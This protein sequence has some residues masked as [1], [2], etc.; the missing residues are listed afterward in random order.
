MAEKSAEFLAAGAQV[1]RPDCRRVRPA[2]V[3]ARRSDPGCQAGRGERRGI[4]AMRQLATLNRIARIAIQDLALRP[5]LQRIVDI[6]HE[7]FDWDFVACA[8]I[9][10][11]ANRFHCEA[12][13]SSV[14]TEVVVGYQRELGTGVV[15]Q[16][17]LRSETI[18]IEDTRDFPGFIDTLGGTRSELCVPVVHDGE[19]LAILNAESRSPRAFHGQR[20]LLETVA[21]Q[22]AGMIRVAK[23]L[24]HLQRTNAQLRDAYARMETL[25]RTD[26]LTGV[27]NRR[28]FDAWLEQAVAD[29]GALGLLMIDVDHF[30]AYNDGYGH[31]AGDACLQQVSALLAYL[32]AGTSGAAGALRRR[33]VRGDPAGA[34]VPHGRGHRRTPARGD[35]G[36]R[37]RASLRRGRRGHHQHRRRRRAR[38]QAADAEGLVRDADTALYAAKHGGRNRVRLA[39]VEA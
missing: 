34:D 6:L 33:R 31:V 12:V 22:I 27:A 28:S 39:T 19:V 7:E 23:L 2:R 38:R 36:A 5:M 20:A 26:E 32:L 10:L 11:E 29:G 13:R 3:I 16:C 37:L 30:K 14:P 1:Y 15:G 4:G 17:A 21:D 9:D 35:R 18:D 25:S 24:D 8:S